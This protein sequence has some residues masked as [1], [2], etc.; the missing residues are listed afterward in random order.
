MKTTSIPS[1]LQI[2]RVKNRTPSDQ[3]L[4]IE[5]LGDRVT[6][7]SEVLYEL[8]GTDEFGKIEIDLSN[9]G[10]IVHGWVKKVIAL[11]GNDS[12]RVEWELTA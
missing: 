2:L 10:F 8:I 5:P 4:W 7:R 11:D 6:L 1:A 9:E 12:E 3:V